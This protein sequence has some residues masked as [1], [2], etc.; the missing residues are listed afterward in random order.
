MGQRKDREG[1]IVNCG[2]RVCER[3]CPPLAC[4]TVRKGCNSVESP[5][6]EN[7]CPTCPEIK[8]QQCPQIKCAAP[9]PGCERRDFERDEN[10][11]QTGCGKE[12]CPCPQILCARPPPGC[13][14][15][16]PRKDENGCHVNCGKLECSCREPKCAPPPPGCTRGEPKTNFLTGCKEGCG[17]L[18]C[19]KK[20]PDNC[21]E[22]YDGCNTCSCDEDGVAKDC[23]EKFCTNE[24]RESKCLKQCTEDDDCS[25][26]QLCASSHRCVSPRDCDR[27]KEYFTFVEKK[28]VAFPG[29]GEDCKPSNHRCQPGLV[30]SA[31]TGGR[32]LRSAEEKQYKCVERTDPRKCTYD[33]GEWGECAPCRRP[34]DQ[35]PLPN[36]YEELRDRKD[37]PAR[38]GV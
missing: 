35:V 34:P 18:I 15:G 13:T 1:C 37:P 30:C 36:E 24:L 32:R 20:C 6:D 7:G 38:G 25:S 9:K 11:C 19:E 3:K 4:P 26:G 23:T 28:C 22:W 16:T 8:C 5:P 17:E 10:G 21:K 27:E 33:W 14:Y 29:K 2:R 31:D 12:V